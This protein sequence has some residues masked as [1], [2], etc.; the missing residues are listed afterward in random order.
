MKRDTCF[1]SSRKNRDSK[2]DAKE[3][4][5]EDAMRID[6]VKIHETEMSVVS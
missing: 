5:E 3:D 2:E 1:T 6:K 4:A